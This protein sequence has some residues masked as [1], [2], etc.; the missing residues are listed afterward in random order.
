MSVG[1]GRTGNRRSVV[2]GGIPVGHDWDARSV[3][4]DR[5]V[6]ADAA[7]GVGGHYHVRTER[8]RVRNSHTNQTDH[9]DHH[10][11]ADKP[12]N[13]TNKPPMTLAPAAPRPGPDRKTT[14]P[15]NTT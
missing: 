1:P 6:A 10:D 12:R 8:D 14:S 2:V 5:R 4:G 13:R 15:P 9:S 7:R 3:K 11:M